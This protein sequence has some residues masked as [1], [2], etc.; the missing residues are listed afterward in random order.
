[1]Y[2]E[3]AGVILTLI[4]LGKYFEAVSKGKTSDAI[5]KLMGLAPKTAHILR[6]GAEIE[7]PV[8]AVQLDDIVI[9]RPGDKIPVDGVIVSGS[10]SVDEAMLTGESL[11]VEKKVGDAVIGASINKNGSFQFKAT[12]VGKET[13]LAQ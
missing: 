10:S 9:V 12:K 11:P 3:S 6:D 7:V 2:Y 1:L 13:A 5:K 8:D 4:T